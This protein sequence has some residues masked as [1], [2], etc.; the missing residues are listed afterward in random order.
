MVLKCQLLSKLIEH[1]RTNLGP[2]PILPGHARLLN[3]LLLLVVVH[4]IKQVLKDSSK[5]LVVWFLIMVDL[6]D[7]L[8]EE[9]QLFEAREYVV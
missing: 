8:E 7:F 4:C 6:L 9:L 1:A 5:R 3:R 2:F